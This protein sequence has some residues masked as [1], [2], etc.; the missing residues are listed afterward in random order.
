MGFVGFLTVWLSVQLRRIPTE[1]LQ[2]RVYMNHG[3]LFE[4]LLALGIGTLSDLMTV[5]PSIVVFDPFLS[6]VW[7]AA[8]LA[9]WAA[10]LSYGIVSLSR[11]FGMAQRGMT[12]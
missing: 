6:L 2:L 8:W 7:T 4:G 11:T 10:F 1:L 3:R 12:Q 5:I 9:T